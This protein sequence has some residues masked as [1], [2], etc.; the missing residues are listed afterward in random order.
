MKG[1]RKDENKT[2]DG[3]EE[4]GLCLH[5]KEDRS[6]DKPK[7]RKEERGSDVTLSLFCEEA[8]AMQWTPIIKQRPNVLA[9]RLAA[10]TWRRSRTWG[11][12]FSNLPMISTDDL[13]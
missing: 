8:L 5:N 13:P 9:L 3:D 11:I 4:D 7:K 10:Y 1:W 6:S 2:G 12:F